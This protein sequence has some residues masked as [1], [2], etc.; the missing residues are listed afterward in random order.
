MED[1]KP[2]PGTQLLNPPTPN[3]ISEIQQS[4][5]RKLDDADPRSSNFMK[6]RAIVKDL[7]PS[8]IEVLH[9]PDFRNCKAANEIRKQMQAVMEL[10]RQLSMEIVSSGNTK[11]PLEGQPNVAERPDVAESQEVPMDRRQEEKAEQPQA[12][13]VHDVSG[14]DEELQLSYIIGGSPIGWNFMIYP[15]SKAVYYGES[16]A[17]FVARQV[18][19][20]P[21]PDPDVDKN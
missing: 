6:I 17:S 9:A 2:V 20:S 21:A 8:F 1:P 13:K 10:S 3:P 4:N 14:A 11:K 18:K 15:G 19:S 12:E 16:K 7:R 5:K